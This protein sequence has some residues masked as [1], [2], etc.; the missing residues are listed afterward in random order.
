M[1]GRARGFLPLGNL[2]LSRDI[3]GFAVRP[4][5]IQRYREYAKIYKEEEEERSERWENFL[6]NYVQS[7]PLSTVDQS[8]TDDTIAK[9]ESLN[10]EKESVTFVES[11]TE[12]IQQGRENNAQTWSDIRPSLD[13]IEQILSVRIKKKRT[14]IASKDAGNTKKAL[15]TDETKH[16]RL[17]SLVSEEDSEEEFY[18]VERSDPVHDSQN[19]ESIFNDSAGSSL[20]SQASLAASCGWIQELESLVRGGVPMALR[21]ELWQAFVGTRIRK[22]DNYYNDLLT[23]NENQGL[24]DNKDSSIVDNEKSNSV[25][26]LKHFEKWK[27]QIEKDIPQTFP[28]HLA[29]DEDGRNALRCLLTAYAHHNPAIGYCQAMNFF[30]GLL[31]LLMPEENAFWFSKL[32][33]LR[34]QI[35]PKR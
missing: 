14:F 22:I 34:V 32:Y 23:M 6:E 29:L 12:D 5:H 2:E 28:G 33:G 30:A 8:G 20:S 35:M 4:Q 9:D 10:G 7:H 21:K 25:S 31:L 3:Y 18:D 19:H 16:S 24:G 1:A 26:N 17:G 11:L 13:A 15:S 27:N